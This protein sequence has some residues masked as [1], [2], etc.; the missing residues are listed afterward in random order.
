MTIEVTLKTI[1]RSKELTDAFI[2]KT[3]AAFGS[4]ERF[5]SFW[6]LYANYFIGGH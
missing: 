4:A 3:E 5:K 6:P 1:G 2:E